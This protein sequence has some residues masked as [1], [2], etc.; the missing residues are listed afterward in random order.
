MI[1]LLHI[2]NAVEGQAIILVDN[3]RKRRG[4]VALIKRIDIGVFDIGMFITC[5]GR[6]WYTKCN[7]VSDGNHIMYDSLSSEEKIIYKLGGL[8]ALLN[9]ISAKDNV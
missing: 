9:Q 3:K 8:D 4:Q 7:H 1:E 6:G 5:N 2:D